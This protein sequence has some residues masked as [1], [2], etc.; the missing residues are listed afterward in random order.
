[1]QQGNYSV[2]IF[3]VLIKDRYLKLELKKLISIYFLYSKLESW[4]QNSA[5]CTIY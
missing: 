4:I 5:K 1:M 2:F 3:S